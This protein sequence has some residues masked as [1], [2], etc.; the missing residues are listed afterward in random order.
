MNIWGF[1]KNLGL[2]R[3]P[4]HSAMLGEAGIS[5]RL[6]FGFE[7]SQEMEEFEREKNNYALGLLEEEIT[8]SEHFRPAK[9]PNLMDALRASTTPF[10]RHNINAAYGRGQ[11]LTKEEKE[12][13]GL[14]QRMKCT[15][16]FLDYFEE[17][18]LRVIDPGSLLATMHH[19]CFQRAYNKYELIRFKKLG[20]VK[21]VRISVVYGCPK[22]KRLRKRWHIDEA[23]EL[24]LAGCEHYD[25]WCVCFYQ[26]IISD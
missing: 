17:P 20:L 7:P 5:V 24:P 13:R 18:S 1:I 11:Y 16:E 4:D 25:E 19:Y 8:R 10:S 15:K 9:I 6:A 23:P 12:A 14:D 3:K 21:Q 26:P 2:W 22:V